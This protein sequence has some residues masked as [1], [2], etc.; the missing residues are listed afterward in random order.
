MGALTQSQGVSTYPGERTG[1]ADA[2]QHIDARNWVPV[3]QQLLVLARSS[4]GRIL[5]GG[6]ASQ[7]GVLA[8][9]NG[10]AALR[11]WSGDA[12]LSWVP[13][14][15]EAAARLGE[16]QWSVPGAGASR[17][18]DLLAATGGTVR[19]LLQSPAP[20]AV[21]TFAAQEKIAASPVHA[22]VAT[23]SLGDKTGVLA[24][25]LSVFD[26]NGK[27]LAAPVMLPGSAAFKSVSGESV[28]SLA[29]PVANAL[30]SMRH[31]DANGQPVVAENLAVAP[32]LKSTQPSLLDSL[33]NVW[34][35]QAK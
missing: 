4:E 30:T 29:G 34:L 17:D 16:A 33:K 7:V 2:V 6:G 35:A 19:E 28:G 22:L 13:A 23:P 32:V 5:S 24:D 21:A 25:L 20:A 12:A 31:F 18:L 11:A 1:I 10:Y 15:V 9:A 8:S 27:A 14:H 26:D 3:S